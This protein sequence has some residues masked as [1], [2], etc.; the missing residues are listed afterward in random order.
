MHNTIMR[1]HDNGAAKTQNLRML[2][3][4]DDRAVDADPDDFKPGGDRKLV[5]SCFAKAAFS[6]GP[7][8]SIRYWITEERGQQWN[9]IRKGGVLEIK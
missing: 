5:L 7:S 4:W 9:Y 8:R 2:D 6:T 1:L 3:I